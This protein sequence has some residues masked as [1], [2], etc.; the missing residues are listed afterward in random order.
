ML[1]KFLDNFKIMELLYCDICGKKITHQESMLLTIYNNYWGK[2]KEADQHFALDLC[3]E[4]TNRIE[5]DLLDS[6]KINEK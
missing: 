5:K 1:E 6:R 4:C 3:G 2:G